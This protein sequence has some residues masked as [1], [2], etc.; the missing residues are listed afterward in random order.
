MKFYC[1]FWKKVHSKNFHSTLKDTKWCM[2][3]KNTSLYMFWIN[4]S[5]K[6]VMSTV[7]SLS[8]EHNWAKASHLLGMIMTGTTTLR[9]WN[10]QQKTLKDKKVLKIRKTLTNPPLK[11]KL[12]SPFQVSAKKKLRSQLLW[13]LSRLNQNPQRKWIK[14]GWGKPKPLLLLSLMVT[15][16]DFEDFIIK[17]N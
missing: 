8:K 7:P 17:S 3:I 9:T 10:N 1:L 16:G 4:K 13:Y 14:L 15:L 2:D 6:A 12:W 11:A 5:L